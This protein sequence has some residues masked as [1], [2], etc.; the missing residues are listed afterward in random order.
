LL[1]LLE[2]ESEEWVG[3]GLASVCMYVDIHTKKI[4]IIRRRR[5]HHSTT[6]RDQGH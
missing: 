1:L 3:L 6:K 5:K 4:I 2:E